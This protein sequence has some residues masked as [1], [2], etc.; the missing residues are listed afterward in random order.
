MVIMS[1]APFR[2]WTGRRE[3]GEER[4]GECTVSLTN[5][6]A[7]ESSALPSFPPFS[8][9]TNNIIPCQRPTDKAWWGGGGNRPSPFP[10]RRR[11][12][13]LKHIQVVHQTKEKRTDQGKHD[14]AHRLEEKGGHFGLGASVGA[15]ACGRRR[16]E[17]GEGGGQAEDEVEEGAGA[18]AQMLLPLLRPLL[19]L[20][21]LSYC[22]CVWVCGVTMGFACMSAVKMNEEI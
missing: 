10:Y 4:K 20:L 17:G 1:S 9:L 11:R 19:L 13:R 6:H 18:L 22:P 16:K 15:C 12:Q 3:G 21:L 8:F 5:L 2:G 7:L 14:Q